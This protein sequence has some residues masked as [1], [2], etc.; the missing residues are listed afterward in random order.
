MSRKMRW[1]AP[2]NLPVGHSIP[3]ISGYPKPKRKARAEWKETTF[4]QRHRWSAAENWG[5][6][7]PTPKRSTLK[8]SESHKKKNRRQETNAVDAVR[9]LKKVLRRIATLE[10]KGESPIEIENGVLDTA[11]RLAILKA[12]ALKLESMLAKREGYPL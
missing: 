10:T 1:P 11:K 5:I 4:A 3:Y 9:Q 7:K 6:G 2:V 8:R 12:R